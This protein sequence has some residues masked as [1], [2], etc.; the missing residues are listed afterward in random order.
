MREWSVYDLNFSFMF[1]SVI[2]FMWWFNEI[3]FPTAS[4]TL[5]SVIPK[6]QATGLPTLK[7]AFSYL[8][9]DGVLLL[10]YF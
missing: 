4:A 9:A 6:Y 7:I 3:A 5:G 2:K 8:I 1:S 10:N